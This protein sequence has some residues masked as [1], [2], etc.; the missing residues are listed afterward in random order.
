[1]RPLSKRMEGSVG[2]RESAHRGY[3]M[4]QEHED[5]LLQY[6]AWISSKNGKDLSLN[7][8]KVEANTCKFS[9]FAITSES[10]GNTHGNRK[11]GGDYNFCINHRW[12]IVT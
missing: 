2:A 9:L 4:K 12:V 7:D 10:K 8:F 1:M 3:E 11:G 5:S 6:L